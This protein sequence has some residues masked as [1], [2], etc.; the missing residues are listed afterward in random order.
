M[1]PRVWTI[2]LGLIN[3]V[4]SILHNLTQVILFYSGQSHKAN[5][6]GI[7]IFHHYCPHSFSEYGA[8]FPLGGESKKKNKR[9]QRKGRY[10]RM[11]CA[12]S[13]ILKMTERQKEL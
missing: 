1:K 6:D 9:K 4:N 7:S 13:C 8:L 11:T 12:F 2:N 3:T 10:L 5:V